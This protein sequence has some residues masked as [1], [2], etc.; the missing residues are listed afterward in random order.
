MMTEDYRR[1]IQ[2]KFILLFGDLPAGER[3]AMLRVS[4]RTIRRIDAEKH[5]P[6]VA[7]AVRME[8]A[9][10]EAITYAT[11]TPAEREAAQDHARARREERQRRVRPEFSKDNVEKDFPK[12][13]CTALQRLEE[14][15]YQTVIDILRD[16]IDDSKEWRR[17]PG[18]I[19]PYV[20]ETLGFAYHFTGRICEEKGAYTEA[21]N[22]LG[23]DPRFS[24]LR[25]TCWSML[26][27]VHLRLEEFNEGFRFAKM[28]INSSRE[29]APAYYQGLCLATA[30]RDP[31]ILAE[32]M[33]R[34]IEA[35]Q[36]SLTLD[37]LSEFLKR[38]QGE[39]PDLRWAQ[40]QERW[41]TF[42]SELQSA[43]ED[44]ER[45]IDSQSRMEG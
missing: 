25:R 12:F 16:R 22:E 2:A 28:A 37:G 9:I 31:Q 32:W 10:E 3:A 5:A 23:D 43:I 15:E 27:G 4:R 8:G 39:D 45:R 24:V 7:I 36:S 14:G 6:V 18:S 42:V 11:M 30:T 34:V 26:A 21:L 40:Q 20:L 29:F 13:M 19:R 33:G 38:C 35:A 17:V 41:K 1:R 44:I